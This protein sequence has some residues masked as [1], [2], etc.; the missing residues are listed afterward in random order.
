[1]DGASLC[2]YPH[3]SWLGFRVHGPAAG[4]PLVVEMHGA[5]HTISLTLRGHHDVR[6]I[7]RGEERR[8]GEDT[9]TVHFLPADDADHVFLTSTPTGFESTVFCIPR[10]H[11]VA[12]AES[13][14]LPQPPELRR[15]LAADD[16]VLRR[17]L[18][19]LARGQEP[20]VCP[21]DGQRDEAARR[22]VLRLVELGGGACR[23]GTTMRASSTAGRSNTSSPRSTPACVSPPIA[24]RWDCRPACHRATSPGSFASRRA[25]A[26]RGSSTGGDCRRRSGGWRMP[27]CLW[28]TSP[29]SSVLRRRATLPGCSAA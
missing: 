21:E 27:T 28:P 10:G 7:C 15:L 12:C 23:T 19:R 24:P 17:C 9:G 3:L 20:G 5:C 16:T 14:G 22:L 13:E 25:S 29:M 26:S 1:M 18:E 11:L 6:W 2:R 8:W 4:P